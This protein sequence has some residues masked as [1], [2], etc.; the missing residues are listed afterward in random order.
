MWWPEDGLRDEGVVAQ[1]GLRRRTGF[2]ER[3]LASGVKKTDTVFELRVS[4]LLC[5]HSR[6]SK[7]SYETCIYYLPSFSSKRELTY[8]DDFKMERTSILDLEAGNPGL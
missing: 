8:L 1:G 7:S 6:H 3:H 5:W 2:L 4:P